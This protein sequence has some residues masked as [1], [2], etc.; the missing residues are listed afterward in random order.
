MRRSFR[1]AMIHRLCLTAEGAGEA[2]ISFG[3]VWD[4]DAAA[5]ALIAAEAG[6]AVTDVDGAP[7]VFNRPDP[8]AEGL[9]A[10]PS[11]LHGAMLAR[12]RAE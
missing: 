11:A 7:L 10:A 9:L 5:G 8:R 12:R 3:R 1:P 2:T 4:W 6:C